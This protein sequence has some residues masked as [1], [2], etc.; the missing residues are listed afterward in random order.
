MILFIQPVVFQ[1]E[2]QRVSLLQRSSDPWAHCGR[3]QHWH[4]ALP[5]PSLYLRGKVEETGL[6][7]DLWCFAGQGE[8]Q[9]FRASKGIICHRPSHWGVCRSF[10]GL[11]SSLAERR[12]CQ[13]QSLA[14][15]ACFDLTFLTDLHEQLRLNSEK[16]HAVKLTGQKDCMTAVFKLCTLQLKIPPTAGSE[17]LSIELQMFS[18]LYLLFVLH[19]IKLF[20]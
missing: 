7:G 13:I 18:H 4:L 14:K 3:R 6:R 19:W 11:F 10:Q 17:S 9:K 8:E 5:W 1:I 16:L 2:E 15:S 20:Q 12:T